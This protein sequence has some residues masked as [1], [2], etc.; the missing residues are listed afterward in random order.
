MNE[1]VPVFG[2]PTLKARAHAGIS[3]A[4]RSARSSFRNSDRCS[5]RPG[6]VGTSAS[7]GSGRMLTFAFTSPGTTTCWIRVIST[8][9]AVTLTLLPAG[10]D[11]VLLFEK[12]TP[13][14]D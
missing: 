8:L 11:T 13:T 6:G 5:G 1:G 2:S 12:A 14:G 3:I 7:R 4:G 10:A 9:V